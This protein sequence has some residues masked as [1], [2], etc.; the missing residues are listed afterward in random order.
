M[1]E[2]R[3]TM[4]GGLLCIVLKGVLAND[5]EH[6]ISKSYGINRIKYLSNRIKNESLI[7]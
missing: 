5:F 1:I 6:A 2:K 3:Q 4:Q 7:V